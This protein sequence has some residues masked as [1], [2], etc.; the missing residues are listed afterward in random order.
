MTVPDTVILGSIS[1][2]A[3][4]FAWQN[5]QIVTSY[6]QHIPRQTEALE[7]LAR[8]LDEHDRLSAEAH[9]DN[10][11]AMREVTRVLKSMQKAPSNGAAKYIANRRKTE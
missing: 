1:A 5:R 2:L 3:G 7:N 9:K 10:C 4:Y 11:S 6:F 8:K